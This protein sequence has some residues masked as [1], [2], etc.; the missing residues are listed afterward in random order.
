MRLNSRYLDPFILKDLEKKMVFLGGPRQVGKTTLAK[1]LAAEMDPHN[2]YLNWD[3][4]A[5]RRNIRA[6]KFPAESRWLILDELHK[7]PSWRNHVKGLFDKHGDRY[8][9][10]VT[11]SARLDYYRRGGDSLWGRYHHYRLH[12]FSLA[13]LLPKNSSA[14]QS[15]PVPFREIM[16]PPPSTEASALSKNLKTFGGFPEPFMSQDLTTLRRWHLDRR[17]RLLEQDIRAVEILRDLT[18]LELLMDLLPGK[19]GSL[20]SLNSLREDLEVNHQTIAHWVDILERFYVHFR[21]P[22]FHAKSIH[23]LRKE[24]KL[25]LWDW[26][27]TPDGGPRQENL[28]ASHLL[29]F[30]HFLRDT[31]GHKTELFYIRDKEQREVD[32]LVTVDRQPWFAVEVK[33]A[34]DRLS[35]DLRYFGQRLN[36][37]FLYQVGD[38]EDIDVFEEGIRRMGIPQFLSGLI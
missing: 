32:F 7:F 30:V 21:L 2:A 14:E 31:E 35:K 15:I 4:G 12:P 27:E 37:P 10:L 33:S 18:K 19:V 38:N 9:I 29:K 8:R 6:L 22:P 34:T 28:V 5:D 3:D 25:Y 24:P 17:Q 23:S 11:G 36:I 20:F 16:F 13:E 26:S 1:R